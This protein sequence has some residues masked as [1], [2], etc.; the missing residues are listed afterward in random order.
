MRRLIHILKGH[1]I[2]KDCKHRLLILED[3]RIDNFLRCWHRRQMLHKD[4]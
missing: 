1:D 3:T 2:R 4:R